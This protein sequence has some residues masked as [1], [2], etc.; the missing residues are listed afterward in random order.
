MDEIQKIIEVVAESS[1]S[2]ELPEAEAN[3]IMI[4]LIVLAL[5]Y[6]VAAIAAIIIFIRLFNH[7]IRIKITYAFYIGII[8]DLL[9]RAT[10]LLLTS[11]SAKN[12][13]NTNNS[14][15][16]PGIARSFVY[17]LLACPDM[18]NCCVYML[19]I[20]IFFS[21]FILAHISLARDVTIFNDNNSD[22]DPVLQGQ[23]NKILYIILS[24]YSLAFLVFAVLTGTEILGEKV[25]P[26]VNSVVNIA[27][28]VFCLAYYFYLIFKFS[29]SPYSNEDSK[30]T[31]YKLYVLVITWTITRLLSGILSLINSTFFLN[32]AVKELYTPSSSTIVM[33]LVLVGYCLLL[34]CLPILLALNSDIVLNYL[35]EKTLLKSRKVEYLVDK[36]NEEILIENEETK[37]RRYDPN[38]ESIET[39][40]RNKPINSN[41]INDSMIVI[42]QE[43]VIKEK[44][45]AVVSNYSQKTKHSLG[46]IHLGSHGGK[47][48]FVREIEFDRLSRYNLEE[49]SQDIDEVM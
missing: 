15:I 17:F 37:T 8:M 25:F 18:I 14:D 16:E 44:E 28:P 40:E 41:N 33:S 48:V 6:G 35:E 43:F 30:K 22:N 9:I 42:V 20:W 13:T 46:Q 3:F 4:T 49:F 19:L 23:T 45:F 38:R 32:V 12:S 5:F 31:V 11:F 29:G 47:D 24:V 27:T 2:S 26:V 1:S 10:T 34:E 39:S 36:N 21:T 7:K